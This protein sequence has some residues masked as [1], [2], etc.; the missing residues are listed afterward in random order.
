MQ[1]PNRECGATVDEGAQV[2][3]QCWADLGASVPS[4]PGEGDA[5]G[6]EVP[7]RAP[8]NRRIRRSAN[9]S[10]ILAILS[11][12]LLWVAAYLVVHYLPLSVW[13]IVPALP[14]SPILAVLAAALFMVIAG[15]A[16]VVFGAIA[17]ARGLRV[18]RS[19]RILWRPLIGVLLGC[20]NVTLVVYTVS[21]SFHKSRDCGDLA[22][23]GDNLK[24]IGRGLQEYAFAHGGKF[25]PLSPKRGV[26]MF[27][28]DSVPSGIDLGAHLTCP[29]IRNAKKSTLGPASPFDD[30]SYFYL[31]YALRS[32][33]AVEA[34]AEAYR[35]RV[36]EGGSFDE[37]LVVE[38]G[39]GKHV[40]HRLSE[41]VKE[42]L[43]AEHDRLSASPY[44]GRGPEY[45]VATVVCDDVPLIIERDL[46]HVDADSD[47][48][49]RGVLVLYQNVGIQYV[50][51]GTWPVTEKT[52]RILAELAE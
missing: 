34:F 51:R 46:G 4:G 21:G 24:L 9:A 50:A 12:P 36:A 17:L 33:D 23:C 10:L 6:A 49:P 47:G 31:G 45:Q 25:P 2:C 42:V 14:F 29:T 44:E 27:T 43:S 22:A 26:L 20:L 11:C 18:P 13:R 16:A 19:G 48:A 8:R 15:L 5:P 32:D 37:D 3:P 30:Q 39:E 7:A 1:C 38:D 40:L 52:Q 41:G 35:K 28:P